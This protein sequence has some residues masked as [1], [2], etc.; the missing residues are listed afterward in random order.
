MKILGKYK[1]P[2]GDDR[3][4]TGALSDSKLEALVLV[5]ITSPG[6]RQIKNSPFSIDLR[7]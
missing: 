1:A 4:K 7:K 6:K 3:Y 5:I 2:F